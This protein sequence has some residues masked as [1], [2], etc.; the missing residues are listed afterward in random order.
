MNSALKEDL[1]PVDIEGCEGSLCSFIAAHTYNIT[2]GRL[3]L[4]VPGEETA[5]DLMQDLKLSG[6]PCVKF[7]WWGTAPYRELTAQ[8][9]IF[10]ERAKALYELAENKDG[11]TI[12][13]IRALLNPLPPAEYIKSLL[14][15]LKP[16]GQIDTASLAKT[17]ASFGYTRVPRVQ[18]CGEFALRGEVLDIFMGGDEQAFRVL[19]DFD[20]VEMIKQFDPVMQG[21]GDRKFSKL[22]IRPVKEVIWSDNRIDILKKNLA[23]CKEFKDGGKSIIEELTA[24]RFLSGEEMFFPLAFEKKHSLLDYLVCEDSGLNT[25]MLIDRERLENMQESLA[26]EYQGLYSK[27]VRESSQKIKNENTCFDFPLPE[28][29]LFNF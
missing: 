1:F 11:I 12:I 4:I 26:R 17:L 29:L 19:F 18:V 15:T 5:L 25:L 8:A 10:G 16:E 20:K 23:S 27:S 21:T 9:A 3:F 13:P 28:R 24:S 2:K 7:P 22:V 6:I 14:V